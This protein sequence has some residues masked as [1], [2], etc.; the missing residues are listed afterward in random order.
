LE[1]FVKIFLLKKKKKKRPTT[2]SAMF[3]IFQKNLQP[4]RIFR[5]R[6]TTSIVKKNVIDCLRSFVFLFLF[7]GEISLFSYKEIG[8]V[9]AKFCFCIVNS[10]NFG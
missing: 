5:K 3:L 10:S 6:Y 9:F 4:K 8:E 2:S 7:S 1:E